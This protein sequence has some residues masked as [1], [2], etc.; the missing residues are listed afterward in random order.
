MSNT[1]IEAFRDRSN[2]SVRKRKEVERKVREFILF[3]HTTFKTMEAYESVV[4]SQVS[5]LMKT[6][7]GKRSSILTGVIEYLKRDGV[8][9]PGRHPKVMEDIDFTKKTSD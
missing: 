1:E 6:L 9:E 2:R 7:E 4:L 8:S 3:D 5:K